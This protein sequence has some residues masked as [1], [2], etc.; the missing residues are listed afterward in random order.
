MGTK[1]QEIMKDVWDQKVGEAYLKFLSE[2]E[3][4]V[5]DDERVAARAI[6]MDPKLWARVSTKIRCKEYMLGIA[7]SMHVKEL[8]SKDNEDLLS[9]IDTLAYLTESRIN[10]KPFDHV[11]PSLL[12]EDEPLFWKLLDVVVGRSPTN[13]HRK[14]NNQPV[15]AD[16]LIVQDLARVF[17]VKGEYV[18]DAL[19]KCAELYNA[20]S[21]YVKCCPLEHP[22]A[23]E[24]FIKL[25]CQPNVEIS[26][27]KSPRVVAFSDVFRFFT[28]R[29][30]T[31]EEM[32]AILEHRFYMF[33][34]MLVSARNSGYD[35]YE[36]SI[37]PSIIDN[38]QFVENTATMVFVMRQ[39]MT[40]FDMEQRADIQFIT[41]YD[42]SRDLSLE[43]LP[44]FLSQIPE[45]QRAFERELTKAKSAAED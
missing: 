2:G 15:Q 20:G 21:L 39:R 32:H 25:A 13:V 30:I 11:S 17:C 3:D 42:G 26:V 8:F 38:K 16:T 22:K 24:G 36:S 34:L 44:P 45:I 43:R 27:H 14:K 6:M 28:L 40:C 1:E 37:E 41:G 4:A 7:H 33:A 9:N 12:A 31:L 10:F 19:I 23:L 18:Y 29:A 35:Y 5:I